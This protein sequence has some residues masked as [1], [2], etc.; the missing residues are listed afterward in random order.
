MT[1]SDKPVEPI[2]RLEDRGVKV[3]A[4][5]VAKPF[6]EVIRHKVKQ[7]KEHGIGTLRAFS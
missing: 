2:L 4:G 6:R 1:I 7:L 3:N 5:N